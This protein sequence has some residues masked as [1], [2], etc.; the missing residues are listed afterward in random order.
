MQ[1]WWGGPIPSSYP[2]QQAFVDYVSSDPELRDCIAGI[3][4]YTAPEHLPDFSF[5]ATDLD[6]LQRMLGSSTINS[7][8]EDLRPLQ[9]GSPRLELIEGVYIATLYNGGATLRNQCEHW[10]DNVLMSRATAPDGF[11]FYLTPAPGA[12]CPWRSASYPGDVTWT[13]SWLNSLTSLPASY[14]TW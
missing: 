10:D 4:L 11:S 5:G 13:Y 12:T 6:L 1:Y 9:V 14:I 3:T 8:I 2:M 7:C